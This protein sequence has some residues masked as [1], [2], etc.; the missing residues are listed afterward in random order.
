[1][2]KIP[3]Q[4]HHSTKRSKMVPFCHLKG[5][6]PKP[7]RGPFDTFKVLFGTPKVPNGTLGCRTYFRVQVR[8][9]VSF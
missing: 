9:G 8:F 4:T 5:V 7:K 6:R 1:M 3:I 2:I